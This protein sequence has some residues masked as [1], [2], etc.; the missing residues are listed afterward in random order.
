MRLGVSGLLLIFATFAASSQPVGHL[1]ERPV[2]TTPAGVDGSRMAELLR[3]RSYGVVANVAHEGG[4]TAFIFPLIGNAAGGNG[5]FFRSEAMFLNNADHGQVIRLF[6]FPAGAQSCSGIPIRDIAIPAYNWYAF[7]DVIADVFNLS[8]LGSLGVIAID[9]FGNFDYTAHMDATIRIYTP[10]PGGGSASQT[11][12]SIALSDYGG[13]EVA[14]GLRHDAGFR[15]NYGIF[16]YLGYTRTFDMFFYGVDNARA[17][18]SVTVAPCS[19]AF[20]GVP[21]LNYSIMLINFVPRD[22]NGGW[23]GFASSVDNISGDSWSVSARP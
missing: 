5:T 7:H 10:A 15:T 23:Y 21:N 11:F 18:S 13:N 16:N 12:D 6:F 9:A 8:G 17:Q 20:N 3:Q 1:A 4:D 2:I 14:F 22:T 19:V